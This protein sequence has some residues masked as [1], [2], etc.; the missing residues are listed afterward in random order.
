MDTVEEWWRRRRARSAS[1]WRFSATIERKI[2]EIP[3]HR[4]TEQRFRIA[5]AEDFAAG[6]VKHLRAAPGVG[7]VVVAGSFRRRKETVGDLD[8]LV[9]ARNG[10]AVIDH[11]VGYDEVGQVLS[12]GTT[13]STVTLKA[14]LQVDVRV[15]PEESY[16][17]RCTTSPARRPTTSRFAPAR[18]IGASSSTSTAYSEKA[19]RRAHRARGLRGRRACPTSSRSSGRP[20]RDRSR[21][22]R[23]AARSSS[24]SATCAAT[25]TSIR[26]PRT[27][28]GRSPRWREAAKA[29]GYAYLAIT[30]HSKSTPP[31]RTGW[32]RS[33]WR[34]SS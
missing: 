12:K 9:T 3:K 11:F 17:A 16:G 33:A 14:G 24:R 20:G 18:R 29:L 4:Q 23:A 5:T 15:V 31:L 26:R 7:Q 34:N 8:I 27:A 1:P 6:L 32:T 10:E 28:R 19:D 21:A 22:G 13:R 30:D 25:S 2:D